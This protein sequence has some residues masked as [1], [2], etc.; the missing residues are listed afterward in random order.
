MKHRPEP[1]A[2]ST[3]TFPTS[4][5][6]LERHLAASI[7]GASPK[8]RHVRAGSTLAHE[9]GKDSK[10]WLI[11]DGLLDV[12]VGGDRVARIGPGAVVGERASLDHGIRTAT[13]R[14]ATP[15]RVAV[16]LA[17]SVEGTLRQELAG[18]HNA[19]TRR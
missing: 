13:L 10:M 17:S 11:L 6:R 5:A 16:L 4:A 19:E 8:V 15:C 2:H 7:M 9:G 1:S 12:E 18:L 3:Y 14:A